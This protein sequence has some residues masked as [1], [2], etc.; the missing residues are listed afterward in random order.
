MFPGVQ[1]YTD[2]CLGPDKLVWGFA[3]RTIFFVFDPASRKVVH[4]QSIAAEFAGTVSHQGPRVFVHGPNQEVY[5]LFT[6][7]IARIEPEN[8]SIKLLAKSPVP[9]G[10][11]GDYLD[12]RIWFASGSHLYSYRLP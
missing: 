6:R 8:W 12:G 1:G 10:A 3:D 11:G 2:L 9:L 4:Q 7:A 5:A